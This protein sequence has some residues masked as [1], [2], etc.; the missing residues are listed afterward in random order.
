MNPKTLK[1]KLLII[2]HI[3]VTVCLLFSW[4]QAESASYGI[5]TALVRNNTVQDASEVAS[6][7]LKVANYT[8]KPVHFHLDYSLPAG[9]QLLGGH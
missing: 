6:N 3:L 5:Q 7:V 1:R 4:V 8:G 2:S 9:W